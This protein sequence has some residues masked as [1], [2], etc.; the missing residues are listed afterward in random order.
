MPAPALPHP[1][2]DSPPRPIEWAAVIEP[3][4]AGQADQRSGSPPAPAIHVTIG[5]IE[6]RATTPAAAPVRR[7]PRQPS[8]MSLDEY[9]KQRAGG[10][11]R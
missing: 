5:R 6:I 4:V 7:Q 8:V 1:A 3:R 10:G 11:P 2:P 9:L